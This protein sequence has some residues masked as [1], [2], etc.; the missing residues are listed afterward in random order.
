VPALAMLVFAAVS[1]GIALT[2]LR[3]MTEV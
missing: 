3:H 2:R 1:S